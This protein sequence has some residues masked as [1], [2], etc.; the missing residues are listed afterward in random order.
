MSTKKTYLG[1]KIEY[2][3]LGTLLE[4]GFNVIYHFWVSFKWIFV[5]GDL[6]ECIMA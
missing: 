1:V 3:Y 4:A 5:I 6:D 2:Y